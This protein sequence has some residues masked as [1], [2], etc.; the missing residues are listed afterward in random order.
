MRS[1]SSAKA[2]CLHPLAILVMAEIGI[3]IS[4]YRSKHWDE[5]LT[6]HVETVITVCGQV[7]RG[8]PQFSDPMN[9]YHWGFDDPAI[10]EGSE[11]AK[12]KV[13]RRV[14]D[15]MQWIFVAYAADRHAQ[16]KGLNSP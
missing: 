2:D 10:A 6:R 12:L 14:R 15:E 4:T 9:R 13:F 3:D 7:G 16:D 8:Y 5:F 11:A 1:A